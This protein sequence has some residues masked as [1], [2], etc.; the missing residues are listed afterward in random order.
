MDDPFKMQV[1][2]KEAGESASE[3]TEEM[4]QQ[5]KE[6]GNAFVSKKNYD[7]AIDIYLNAVRS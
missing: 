2:R 1:I 5:T 4:L 7:A 3:P 6:D